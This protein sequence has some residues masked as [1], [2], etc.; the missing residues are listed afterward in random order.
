MPRVPA[1][2]IQIHYQQ[3]G[4]GPDLVLIHGLTG[5]L[6]TWY[7]HAMPELARQFRVTAYDLRG[8]GYSEMTASGYT[9]AHMA[10]DLHGLLEALRIERAHLVGHSF[11]GTI[12]LHAAVLYPD[13]VASVLL[14]EPTIPALQRFVDLSTW[15]Y[16]EAARTLFSERGL[17]IPED[18]WS[19]LEY[20]VRETLRNPAPWGLRRETARSGRRLQRLLDTTSAFKEAHEVAGLTM[21]RM[22]EVRQP[23]AAIFGGASRF[24]Q[25]AH[26]LQE[27]L[28]ACRLVVIEGVAHLFVLTQPELLVAEVQKFLRDLGEGEAGEGNDGA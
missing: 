8:H 5:D 19:D 9:S 14:V 23:I 18:K 26:P 2:G 1:N 6:T 16:F 3:A 15:P 11:G 13:R 10:A 12:A 25:T 27:A 17:S 24:L 7:L 28:P 21:E 4:Q 22:G 20:L